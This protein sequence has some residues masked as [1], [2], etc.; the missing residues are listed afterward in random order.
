M[1]P[2]PAPTSLSVTV[3]Q[4]A[5]GAWSPRAH[6]VSTSQPPARPISSAQRS[7]IVHL[8]AI[9]VPPPKVRS[10]RPYQPHLRTAIARPPPR[11]SRVGPFNVVIRMSRAAW[12]AGRTPR[13]TLRYIP[14]GVF[15]MGQLGPLGG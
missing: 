2:S 12:P 1:S 4:R 8:T 6:G 11:P 3:L 13:N 7:P 9:A 5:P 14:V 10:P 15:E